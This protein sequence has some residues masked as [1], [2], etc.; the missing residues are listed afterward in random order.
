MTCGG[1]E[2]RVAA[3]AT[4]VGDFLHYTAFSAYTYFTSN[5]LR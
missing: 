1:L 4:S 5:N 3:A 2:L